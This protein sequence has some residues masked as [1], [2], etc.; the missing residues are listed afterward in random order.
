MAP[1]RKEPAAA[2]PAAATPAP[3]K[4]KAD[5]AAKTVAPRVAA[6]KMMESS[7]TS[8]Y[9]T[10]S[11]VK[12]ERELLDY[13]EAAAKDGQVSDKEAH[14]LWTMAMDGKG[15]TD[16]EK[17]TLEY[18]LEHVKFTDKAATYLKGKLAE[19]PK[20]VPK[21]GDVEMTTPLASQA[22]PELEEEKEQDAPSYTGKKVA[23]NVGFEVMEST[24][25]TVITTEGRM[26][27]CLAEGGMQY[28]IAG[29]R[30]NT[31]VK[32][33]RYMFEVKVLELLN[34]A[35]GGRGKGRPLAAPWGW[36]LLGLLRL[37]RILHRGQ[38]E[39]VLQQAF[40]SQ[41]GSRSCAE[42]GAEESE[43]EYSELFINGVRASS[44]QALPEALKGKALFPHVSFRAVTMQVHFGPQ[45]LHQ[46]PFT[47]RTVQDAGDKDVVV[48]KSLA[49][50]DGKYEVLFPVGFPDEGTFEWLDAFL[51]KNPQY[52]ELSDRKIIDWA[53]K[54]GV[55]KP[56]GGNWKGACNDK[57]EFN[58]GIPLMDDF[59]VRRVI[60]SIVSVVPRNY[61][62]MEV[63]ENLCL[64]DRKENLKRFSHPDYRKVALVVM[65][66]PDGDFK[67]LSQ[68]K[69]LQA[70]KVK[71][72]L[73]WRQQKLEKE[74]KKQLAKRL[75]EAELKRKQALEAKAKAE[76]EKK[77]KAEGDKAKAE[78]TE[79]EKKEEKAEESKDEP[80]PPADEAKEE[81][82]EDEE[83][84]DDADAEPPAVE[85]TAEEKKQW[86]RPPAVPDLAPQVL[87]K[88][89]GHFTI[90]STEEGFDDIRYEWQDA[91]T[92]KSYLT[93]WVSERKRTSKVEDIQPGEWFK[94]QLA[95]FLKKTEEWKAKQKASTVPP[96]KVAPKADGEDE[97]E[98]E[99]G[100]VDIFS[101]EDI[102]NIGN[103][104]VLFKL[105]GFE[106]WALM[107]L[108]FELYLLM[109]AFKKDVGD[110]ERVITETYL[111]FYFQ[112][113]Y[114]RPLTPKLYG[115]ENFQEMA[116][117]VKDT[118]TIDSESL[119]MNTPLSE[120][121]SF[122]I[123]VKLTEESRRERQRRID[124]G[125]ETARLKFDPLL[126]KKPTVMPPQAPAARTPAT[127][128]TPKMPHVKGKGGGKW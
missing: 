79:G 53:T 95:E 64:A 83:K 97:D 38:Q 78:G 46:L 61:V 118:V 35:D 76:E 68:E 73:E 39:N 91:K 77:K 112:R 57:P 90:P 20:A 69:L 26:L 88:V 55:W 66:E 34:L 108:R 89:F 114:G 109:A 121:E 33:G 7:G 24:V 115:K 51:A 47:C 126:Q 116:L 29:A 27:T 14:T 84:D 71:A 12:Y 50:K 44:P 75:K 10:I 49:P 56:R 9:K 31:G 98:E 102:C 113:Y 1:K 41:S 32:A 40:Q 19:M 110:P 120:V 5:E 63:K 103:G 43:R 87:N 30:A 100:N 16:T 60:N 96:K 2:A 93:K 119:S 74:R 42:P 86:F 111:P 124:A 94:T 105:F 22:K 15:V 99:S 58:F 45:P 127:Y 4:A 81:E 106:D 25:N 123:F 8:Q 122:D 117:M 65:G 52:T 18:I 82:A 3:K 28:L 6:P 37:R 101:V 92:S 104:E 54:S 125:D 70:K 72:D 21:A 11:G 128:N 13:A 85:L 67:K 62:V 23:G 36:G 59:S 48:A 17:R 107:T 80:M